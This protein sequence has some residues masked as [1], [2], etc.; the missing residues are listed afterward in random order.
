MVVSNRGEAHPITWIGTGKVLA[1]R[2]RRTAATPV[3]VRKGALADSVPN[4]DLHI[5]KGHSLYLDG[6]LIPVEFLVN[7]RSIVWDDHAQEVE[8]YHV[9]LATH[10]VLLA[11]GAP[12]ESYRD[13]GNRWL[14]RNANSGWDQGEKAACAPVLTG[15][16]VVDAVWRRLLDRAGPRPGLPLSDDPDLH[17][18][19]DGGRVD[20]VA[21]CGSAYVFRLPVLARSVRIVSR[22]AAPAE[23]GLARDPRVL[24]VALSGIVLR[25]GSWF[26]AVDVANPVLSEGFHGF[27]PDNGLRWTNGDAAL[28]ASLFEGLE[29]SKELVLHVGA[30]TS[31]PLLVAATS[32]AAA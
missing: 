32:R 20:A 1:T 30:T 29:G 27:E 17:V 31:Y 26:R 14:F 21:R 25:Q 6:A 28:P 12:A 7:H 23:L 18:M 4:R 11:N 13:D 8:I 2:G 19:V 22:T 10:G 5:T 16:A 24:G 3:I 15:G 9:E